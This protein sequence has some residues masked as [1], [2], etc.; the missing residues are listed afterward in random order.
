M[1]REWSRL[2]LGTLGAA[3]LTLEVDESG[4]LEELE[5]DPPGVPAIIERMLRRATQL[6][7]S[8]RF[9]VDPRE[10]S[11]GA[12][13]L[14]LEVTISERSVSPNELAAPE[15][16]FAQS[17][18]PPTFERAG[19]A[20]FTLNSGRHIRVVVRRAVSIPK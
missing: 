11:A 4:K 1:D 9:S 15:E 18:A 13:H 20:Q 19:F 14:E 6:L 10:V 5:I 8:G 3:K 16:L 12:E 2:P 7:R 17:S